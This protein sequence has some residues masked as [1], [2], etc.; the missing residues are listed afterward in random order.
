MLDSSEKMASNPKAIR[1]LVAPTTN[2]ARG[3]QQ[4]SQE[5]MQDV[6]TVERMVTSWTNALNLRHRTRPDCSQWRCKTLT[7]M[8]SRMSRAMLLRTLMNQDCH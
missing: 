2:K 1:M 3:E 5:R 6:S 8:E 7:L 4:C